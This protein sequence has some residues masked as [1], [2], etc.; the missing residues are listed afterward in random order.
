MCPP[1]H[2]VYRELSKYF[3]QKLLCK[4]ERRTAID[5]IYLYFL[6]PPFL[7]FVRSCSKN[8]PRARVTNRNMGLVINLHEFQFYLLSCRWFYDPAAGALIT[9][10]LRRDE[11]TFANEI[12]PAKLITR[13][14]TF[15]AFPLLTLPL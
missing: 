12:F 3:T 4:Y 10:L 7:S 1:K 6:L 5:D 8:T 2:D 15:L 11:K 14:E 9:G 13:L